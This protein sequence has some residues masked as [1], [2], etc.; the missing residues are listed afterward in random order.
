MNT[1]TKKNR[2]QAWEKSLVCMRK[3]AESKERP[4][5]FRGTWIWIWYQVRTLTRTELKVS[6]VLCENQICRHW[7]WS[8]N[9]LCWIKNCLFCTES[10]MAFDYWIANFQSSKAYLHLKQY[11]KKSQSSPC[12]GENWSASNMSR[13]GRCLIAIKLLKLAQKSIS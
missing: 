7:R 4:F 13:N 12:N 11:I 8:R 2:K 10:R 9:I 1:Q 3:G 6:P 5:I